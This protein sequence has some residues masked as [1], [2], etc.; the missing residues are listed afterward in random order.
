MTTAELSMIS[1][2]HGE[3]KPSRTFTCQNPKCKHG[4]TPSGSTMNNILPLMGNLSLRN[5]G[6]LFEDESPILGD[7]AED[8]E[9]VRPSHRRPPL[10]N[11][12]LS[13]TFSPVI[14]KHTNLTTLHQLFRHRPYKSIKKVKSITHSTVVTKVNTPSYSNSL[15]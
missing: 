6:T 14:S 1:A 12:R 13:K 9:P 11:G 2:N 4:K 7:R 3:A 8:D 10:A 5:H 15:V